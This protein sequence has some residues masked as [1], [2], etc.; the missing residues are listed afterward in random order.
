[1]NSG[2]VQD[3]SQIKWISDFIWNIADDRLRDVYVRGKYRDVILPFTVLRRLDAV[4]EPTKQKVL[5]RK[6]FLDKNKVAEQ[7]GALRMA[8]GQAFYNVSEFTLAK[9]KAASQ[10]QRLRED[11]IAYLDG[12]SPNVQE[13]L[14]KF[15]FRD[16][17]QT[18]VDAHVLGY[19]IEDFLDPDINLSPLPVKDADGRIK[20][21][22]LDNHGMGTVF[23]EL[24]RRFNE[25]NN[26]EAGEHFTPRDVVKL[27]AKLLF[28]PVAD[29][30]QSGT[31]LL[32]DGACGTGGML[33]VAEE[34]LQELAEEHGKEV[35]IHLFG[36]EINPETY[37][38][39]K[40]D[41]L[42]KG[43][44]DEAEHIVGGADKST[45][46]AD[47]FRA[48]EFDFMISNPPY[49]KSWKTDLERMGGKQGLNDPRFI[50]S[51]GGDPEFRLIT[52]TSD[53][54]LMFLVNK[55]QK[56]KKNSPLG[57]R[58]AIVHNGSALFTGDAGQGE[59]NIRRWVIENDWLEA[60]I[61]LPLNIFYNTGIATYIWV[62]ANRKAEHRKG[63]VQLIDASRW[64]QPLRRNLGK[65]N[66]ELTEADIQ[67]VLD[68]Y[69]GQPQDTPECK[70]FD[71][72]DF[73]YWK[74]T[75]ERPL[76]LKSQLKRAAIE[77]L[78]FA[79]GD[80]PL[81][82]ELW[83]RY[84]DA[85]YTRLAKLKPEIEAWLKGDDGD[86]DEVSEG[87][88]ESMPARKAVPEKRRKKLLDAAT[89]QRDKTLVELALLAR[90]ELGDGVFDDHNVFR[91]R[92]DAAMAR[93]GKKP[94]AA[95]K[96]A[97]FKAVSWRD[98]SAP[99]VIARRTKLKKNERFAPGHDGV[100]LETAGN[101]R[102]LVEYEP[103]PELRD[104]EQVPLKETGG[105]EAFFEREVLPHA[106]DAWIDRS[107]TQ[108]GYEIS[109]ARY[110]YQ[111]APL[112]TLDEIRADILALEQQTEGLLKKIVGAA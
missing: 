102:F 2:K 53:G 25:E 60:I 93:H 51:H 20:L 1:M 101:D 40:A 45:L 28:L 75:V 92:F 70:W 88:D 63:R 5:E 52:R 57:S 24:I 64:F 103:D 80:E 68:H 76:R 89:W 56:M 38:I 87:E 81:R 108:I 62:L 67:R 4:L 105:I 13:I 106:P 35:S 3:Q 98:E 99:P 19:L 69:L 55:L 12:F 111:P 74:I 96:K 10:G 15:K 42:L 73:G 94:A 104:T 107:K 9:L 31:Y 95:E 48:R 44:G 16:Q 66:C 91:E 14:T 86:E 34:T 29:Q 110:F 50:V 39:C 79:S 23:E 84:G 26:E 83:A 58:I 37:A 61:A 43:E 82:A 32:Y 6:R 54:Q 27:M 30:I 7:D 112:R 109:F 65:K 21:P 77:N 49:G 11:F 36:Q 8:A 85:L 47:Q 90:Q 46:S 18:L 59:S 33:T 78:R 72:A 17:I 41:L 100:T 22:A 71:N 97:I